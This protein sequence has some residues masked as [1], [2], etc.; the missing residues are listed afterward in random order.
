MTPMMRL[1]T[2]VLLA[3][4]LATA[5]LAA[6]AAGTAVALPPAP[7]DRGDTGSLQRGAAAFVNYCS[8]CHSAA[9][10]RYGH[11]VNDL[12]IP[13]DLLR[14]NLIYT[15]ASPSD[16]M[17][18]AMPAQKAAEWFHQAV[19][20]DL[21]LSAK[22]HGTDWLYAYMRSFY[23]DPS[24]PSGWNNHIFENV[25]MPHVLA[26]L[27]GEMAVGEAGEPVILRAGRLSPAAYDL[28]I[29]DLVNF[30]DYMA[31]P[32]RAERHRAGYVILS[33]LLILF[34]CTYFLYREYWRDIH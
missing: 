16:G 28:L 5:S 26:D 23:R 30:M 1:S 20:P 13:E 29:T 33:I 22:L 8:G 34:I 6:H 7:I 24:R 18:S 10:M 21:T 25:A 2:A 9:Y 19:P 3:I 17:L 15:E 11:F 12:G 27:Q 14:S 31:E 32:T 4:W